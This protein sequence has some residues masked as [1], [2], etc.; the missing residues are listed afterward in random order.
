[1]YHL[2]AREDLAGCEGRFL[3]RGLVCVLLVCQVQAGRA[4][5]ALVLL[6]RWRVPFVHTVQRA[7]AD[8]PVEVVHTFTLEKQ[9]VISKTSNTCL[10]LQ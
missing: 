1:M 4:A 7:P 3:F 5:G 2:R 10:Q 9:D 6:E 8:S